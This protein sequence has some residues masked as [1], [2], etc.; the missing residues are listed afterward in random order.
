MFLNLENHGV[1]LNAVLSSLAPHSETAPRVKIVM[2][3]AMPS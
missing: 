3:I 1:H 2:P